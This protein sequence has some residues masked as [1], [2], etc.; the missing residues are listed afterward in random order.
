MGEYAKYNGESIKI[1]TCEDMYYLR[2]DQLGL[3]KPE[4]GNVDIRDSDIVKQLRFRFPFPQEDDIRPGGFRDYSFGVRVPN[5]YVIPEGVDHGHVQFSAPNG[6]LLGVP[7][8]ESPDW[9]VEGMSKQ[10]KQTGQHIHLNGYGG[11]AKVVQQRLVEGKLW[12][13]CQ[14]CGCGTKWRLD[15]VSGLTLAESFLVEAKRLEARN[16]TQWKWYREMSVRIRAGYLR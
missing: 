13:V 2:Y 1:G 15:E 9:K 14:C 5:S 4:S 8:P 10:H 3:V 11:P 12:T 7:C 16:D 6:Y